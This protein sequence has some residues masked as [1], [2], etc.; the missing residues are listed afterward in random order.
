MESLAVTKLCKPFQ[1]KGK[2]SGKK[3]QE[4]K[5]RS[6]A[7]ILPLFDLNSSPKT[8]YKVKSGLLLDVVVGEGPAVL[9]LLAGEDQPL[10]VRGDALLVLGER[11]RNLKQ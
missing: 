3:N 5:E 8:Q 6:Q 10:L 1:N 11:V 4:K 9:Q 2:F 7:D